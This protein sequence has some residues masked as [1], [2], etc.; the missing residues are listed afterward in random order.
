MINR[1]IR[2]SPAVLTGFLLWP[3]LALAAPE[4]NVLVSE[5]AGIYQEAAASLSQTLSRDD[6]K[7]TLSTPDR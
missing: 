2:L 7:I 3:W 1:L 6:W 5:P 4:I